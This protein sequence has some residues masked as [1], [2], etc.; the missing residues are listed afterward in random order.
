MTDSTYIAPMQSGLPDPVLDRQFYTRVTS[1][2]LVAWVFDAVIIS[3]FALIATVIV[4]LFTLGIGFLILPPIF[5]TTSFIYRSVTIGNRSATWG[6][7]LMGIELRDRNGDRF[8]LSTGAI[9]T[10]LYLLSVATVIGWLISVIMMLGTPRGQGLPDML[11]G[12]AAINRPL[13]G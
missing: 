6:M 4:A 11:L 2:R 8:D 13:H 12:S 10:G 7:R 5:L 3:I 1:K 9:H